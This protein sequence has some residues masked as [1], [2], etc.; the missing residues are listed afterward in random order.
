LRVKNKQLERL[1]LANDAARILGCSS[2]QVIK[3]ADRGV[4]PLVGRTPKNVRVM[5]M[6]DLERLAREQKESR[7]N[8]SG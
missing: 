5:R 7:P 4:I 1:A 3:L 8:E 2:S 6:V